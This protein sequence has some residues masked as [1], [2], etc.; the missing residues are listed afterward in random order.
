MLTSR[1]SLNEVKALF[2]DV[3]FLLTLAVCIGLILF[4]LQDFFLPYFSDELWVY[5]PSV[6]KMGLRT[7]SM[8]PSAMPL[9]DHYAHPLLFFFLGGIWC[10]FFGGSIL[11]T[12][13]FAASLSVS[14]VLIIY[15][16]G[17]R[18]FN[19]EIGFYAMLIFASQNI[20]IG[21]FLLVLPEVLLTIFTF[22]TIY[23]YWKEK[24]FIYLFFGICLVL[25][26]ETGVILIGAIGVWELIKDF[27][28]DKEKFYIQS[29]SKKYFLIG[30]PLIAIC[31][32]LLLLKI[33]YGWF[34]SP[35]R[36]GDFDF[37]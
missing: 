3:Y 4:K 15:V 31:L 21:Q 17:K 20:F 6:R 29:F 12:H 22:L 28:Y 34:I 11:S 37:S 18:V 35:L 30:L 1:F 16:F 33:T 5:G 27:C 8:L 7:P 36:L 14:L 19:R 23:F 2:R 10:L 26:K 25:T 24:Y 9:E 13:I 32:H